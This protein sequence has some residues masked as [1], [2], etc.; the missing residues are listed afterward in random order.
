MKFCSQCG[1]EV[2]L[3]IP[4]G[5]TLPRFV[6]PVCHTIHY[7]NPKMVV[8]CIPEWKGRILLCRRAIA[9]RE[10]K[11]TLPAGFMENNETLAQGAARETLEEANA[12]VEI[13]ELYAVYN[14]PH[15]SQVYLLFRAK[16]LDL[17]FSPGIESL[18]V[19]L[20]EEHEI[21]WDEMA[22]RVIHDPLKRYLKERRQGQPAFHIGMIDRSSS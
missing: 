16:L 3:R 22:F 14:L 2:E 20:F 19:K 11:W 7:Q 5:D 15:I 13:R 8:G 1:S 9:P 18:E 4:T 21:P 12:R 17:D 6:C 10:G